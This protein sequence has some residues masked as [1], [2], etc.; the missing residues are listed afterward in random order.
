MTPGP[1]IVVG[2]ERTEM[3]MIASGSLLLALLGIDS[4][5]VGLVIGPVVRTRARRAGLALAFGGCDGVATLLGACCPH[6]VPDL[7]GG[8]L[9][10]GAA[11]AVML[12]A[13]RSAGWLLAAPLLLG[14]DNLAS[15]APASAAL[16]L[17]ASSAA[18]AWAGLAASAA[19]ARAVRT[20][21]SRPG[22]VVIARLRPVGRP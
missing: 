13:R 2:S 9:Y 8:L 10:A 6:A 4:L 15:G 16:P 21:R 3:D 14:L 18:M 12:A 22:L 20:I 19:L 1:R 17:A 7:P 5:L 11:A